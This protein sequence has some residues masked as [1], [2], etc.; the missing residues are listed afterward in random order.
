MLHKARE[1]LGN[2][3]YKNC[4]FEVDYHGS[5][6]WFRVTYPVIDRGIARIAKGRRWLLEPDSSDWQIAATAMKAV[7]TVEEHEARE[8]F[9]Y[10]GVA[11]FYP[12]HDLEQLVEI[13]RAHAAVAGTAESEDKA[14]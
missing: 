14:S 5:E 6:V 2:I 11:I 10:K 4:K 1:V 7:L 3:H 13:R 9:L 12:H 8:A